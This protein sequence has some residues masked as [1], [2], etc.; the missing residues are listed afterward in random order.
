ML[1]GQFRLCSKLDT[2]KWPNVDVVC[3]RLK[4][5]LLAVVDRRCLQDTLEAYCWPYLQANERTAGRVLLAG[6]AGCYKAADVDRGIQKLREACECKKVL[7][8]MGA[9]AEDT[10]IPARGT[11]DDGPETTHSPHGAHGPMIFGITTVRTSK[12]TGSYNPVKK[13]R[14]SSSRTRRGRPWTPRGSARRS[15]RRRRRRRRSARVCRTRF[16]QED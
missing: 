11:G 5:V 4:N 3:E 8:R 13:T 10:L 1:P 7:C 15:R 6:Y 9:C 14:P 16:P 2:G 12:R